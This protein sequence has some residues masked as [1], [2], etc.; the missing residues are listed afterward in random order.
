MASR[1]KELQLKFSGQGGTSTPASF[2][3]DL[4][5]SHAREKEV[6]RVLRIWLAVDGLEQGVLPEILDTHFTVLGD[7]G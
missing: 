4:R 2:T 7:E 1:I 3:E 6:D 5:S